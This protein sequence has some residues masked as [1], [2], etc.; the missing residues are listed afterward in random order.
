MLRPVNTAD[1]AALIQAGEGTSTELKSTREQPHPGSVRKAVCALANSGGGVV[2]YGVE[3]DG[4]VSGVGDRA[5]S[6]LLQRLVVDAVRHIT[7][8][9]TVKLSPHEIDGKRVIVVEVPGFLAARPFSAEGRYYVRDGPMSREAAR[10]ELQALFVAPERATFD[11]QP[12]DGLHVEDLDASAIDR[13]MSLGYAGQPRERRD[14]LLRALHAFDAHRRVTVCGALLFAARPDE[15][16][17]DAY[18]TAIRFP[19]TAVTTSFVAEE[20]I[21]GPLMDQIERAVAFLRAAVPAPSA[22]VGTERQV[23]GVPPEV[24]HEAVSNAV[25]HRDYQVASQTRVFVF[26]DRVEIRNPGTLLN[27]LTIDGI[28]LGGVS[29]RRNP[30]V[31]AVLARARARE[32]AGLGVPE[33]YERV[34]AAH[35][36]E[37]VIDTSNGE[38]RLVVR[39]EAES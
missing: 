27:R 31:A 37:P 22:R 18:L 34:R 25:A 29:Q 17:R 19:G 10:H 38:F 35:L 15:H 13:V 5:A 2:V 20:T 3:D 21:R 7:P 4:T 23:Q 14:A 33:I 36:P 12:L 24:W 28:R 26:S 9:L 6:D 11:E 30:N 32:N 39:T 1:V 8:A 16:V